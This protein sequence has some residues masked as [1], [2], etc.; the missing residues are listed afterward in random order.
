MARLWERLRGSP[1]L[2]GAFLYAVVA[3]LTSNPKAFRQ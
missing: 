2:K 3:A 1:R